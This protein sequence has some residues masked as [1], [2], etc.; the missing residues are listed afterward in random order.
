MKPKVKPQGRRA[1]EELRGGEIP[2][3]SHPRASESYWLSSLSY[4]ASHNS[5]H[6]LEKAILSDQLQHIF[7]I[8][9]FHLHVC[10]PNTSVCDAKGKSL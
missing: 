9:S 8:F 3:Q 1:A 5:S 2:D 4:Y 6:L 10:F 7:S